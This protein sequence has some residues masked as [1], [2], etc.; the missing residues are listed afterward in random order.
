MKAKSRVVINGFGRIGRLSFKE[1]LDS[2]QIDLVA[3]NDLSDINSLG[4]LLK[5][6]SVHG[7]FTRTVEVLEDFILLDGKKIQVFQE[8]DPSKLPW[9]SLQID[10]VVECT[11]RFLTYEL[12]QKHIDAGAKKVILSAPAKD[13]IKTIVMGVNEHEIEPADQIISNASCTTNCLAPM[14][15]VLEES[16]GVEKGYI[17]T[18]HAYT[19]D[20]NIQD[21]PHKDPRRARA[22][23]LSIIPTTTGAATAVGKVIPSMQGKLDG[24]AF[25]VPVPDGSA[26]DLTAILKQEVDMQMVLNA[27]KQAANSSLKGILRYSEDPIVSVDIIGDPSSCILDA[28]MTSVNGNLIKLVGWYDNEYG[29]A[30]R[31]A[32]LVHY[33]ASF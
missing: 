31:I 29:Y 26:T 32:D 11:G 23:A 4:H 27:F 6:D 18:I 13:A 8:A 30:S 22:A 21:A 25:R 5:Y 33:M 12:A 19:A 1:L 3:I 17:S 14:I 10:F 28:P 15:K 16:F 9:E 2:D 7:R 24:I 20:Q